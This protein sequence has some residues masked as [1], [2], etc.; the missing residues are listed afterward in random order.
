MFFDRIYIHC[1]VGY[2]KNNWHSSVCSPLYDDIGSYHENGT[3]FCVT[4]EMRMEKGEVLTE[5]DGMNLL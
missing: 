5:S 3:A 2:R 4:N 1:S